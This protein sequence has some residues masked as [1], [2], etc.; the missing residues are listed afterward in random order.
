MPAKLTNEIIAAAI[1]GFEAQKTRIDQQIAELRAMLSG[2]LVETAAIPEI[3]PKKRKI[4][5]AAR[6]R[7]ALGQKRRWA[8]IEGT[9]EPS[10]PTP[11]EPPKPKRRI[12]AEG[13][14]KIIAATK[15]RWAK[16]RAEKAAK[17][18]PAAAKK[19]ATKKVAGKKV[20]KKT[21]AKRTSKALAQVTPQAAAS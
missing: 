20:A 8:A 13:M 17:A 19:A 14:R 11:P 12:S 6:R 3:A 5:A 10:S 1:E 2:R 16:V 9:A 15:R 21:A 7:M 4:S 18:P